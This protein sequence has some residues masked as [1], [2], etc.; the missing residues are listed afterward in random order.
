[1]PDITVIGA[2]TYEN[3]VL[4]VCVEKNCQ[5]ALHR[6][7]EFSHL[8]LLCV[9]CKNQLT[10]VS[11]KVENLDLKQGTFSII[12]QGMRISEECGTLA[13]VDIK[14]YIPSEDYALTNACEQW[15]IALGVAK[16]DEGYV[17]ESQ[18]E[19]RNTHGVT[20]LQFAQNRKL[21]EHISEYIHVVWWF[22][23]FEEKQF[24]RVMQCNPPYETGGS[25][26]VFASRSPVR[27]NPIALT[28]ARVEKIEEYEKRIYLSGIESFDHTPFLGILNY[29]MKMDR[30]E[31]KEVTMPV[32]TKGWPDHIQILN[33]EEQ[34]KTVNELVEELDQ[35][36]DLQELSEEK[37]VLS[38][39]EI[40]E[41]KPTH[42]VVK[43]ASEN[44]LKGISVTIPYGKIT[45]VVGVSGSG[46]SSLVMDTVYAECRRRMDNLNSDFAGR[47]RPK[48][49]T[50]TG[51]MPV[52][53]ISQK[54]LRANANSTVGTFT[55]VYTHL[56]YIYGTIG[57]QQYRN[58]QKVAFSITPGTFSYLDSDCRC[59]GCNGKG[60]QY[61]VDL[62]KLV[63]NPEKSLL[64]GASPFYGRLKSYIENPN[65]NWM[66]GQAVALAEEENVDLRLPWKELPETFKEK[67]LYGDETKQ[68][69]FTYDN[70]KN[71]RTGTIT[72][73]V[74]G[75]IPIINRLY[76]EDDKGGVAAKYMSQMPCEA[77]RGERL[78]AE[79]RLVTV[80]GTRYPVA[81]KMTFEQ[82]ASFAMQLRGR[83]PKEKLALI[84]EHLDALL[85]LCHT[86]KRLG[87]A[88]IEINRTTSEVSGGEAQRLKLLAA[89]QNH[90]TGILYI[91][92]EPS[93]KLSAREYGYIIN[94]MRELISQGNTIL[95]VEHNSDMI[96]IADYVIEI[97]PCAGNLG[98]Y[99]VAEG[100]YEDVVA[101]K[102]TMIGSYIEQADYYDRG[103]RPIRGLKEAGKD[104]ATVSHVT[105]HNLKDVTVSFPKRALTCITGVS[106]SGKSSLLYGGIL[107]QME[108]TKEFK[109]VVLVESKI[110][111]GNAR[112]VVATY[113]GIMDDLRKLYGG[114]A[115]A[116][117]QGY[118][119]KD[120][121]FNGGILRCE[122]CKG[123][124]RIKIPYTENS[125]NI[126]PICHG[127]RYQA[128]AKKLLW[129]D[130]SIVDVLRMSI[131]EAAEFFEDSATSVRERCL[132]LL[133]FGL[134]YV[135]LGQSTS[136]LSGGE[137]ARLKIASCLMGTETT[138]T[139]FLLDEPTCGL[140][141]SD[142]DNLIASLYELIDAGNTVVAI[143]HNKRFLS[144]ADYTITVGPGAGKY[145]GCIEGAY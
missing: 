140:H 39:Q 114:L 103:D 4:Q 116:R 121:S 47:Q 26:G 142:I 54:E 72:R 86:A 61:R 143:E 22:D 8:H 6:I 107:P 128:G 98:G 11:G 7:E 119:D 70:K 92:D 31:A 134:G 94:L 45:A 90:M 29:N 18:G 129:K 38:S 12:P 41:Q 85:A 93:K 46:K 52:V 67:L 126:C 137:A 69:S 58:S 97:G 109:Q 59:Q 16:K 21:P 110:A 76:I 113:T 127:D 83:L 50:M 34:E 96:R 37:P 108:K 124:G 66:K 73:T 17:V 13:L 100:T 89:F 63:T 123:D 57:E 1:M 95:M 91:F 75:M 136:M 64:D 56:R 19:I 44:N 65:A 71:G 78:A 74:E 25:I 125:Y 35:K 62:D 135:N 15:N 88:Y 77:C 80:M 120:F 10:L 3:A 138:N 33:Q 99:L 105:E 111:G 115:G 144:A 104:I 23:H 122:N 5:K 131:E 36:N 79:G 102:E 133:K 130:K 28:V 48:M 20:Y 82:L 14:P 81:A 49:D 118:S 145:G 42:I 9:M 139:L 132:L 2:V 55:G 141:F 112:S 27:P 40:L 51:C 53:M 68:I 32:W 24:R 43:G 106:G 87:I 30:F 117:V 101:N 84:E 60:I